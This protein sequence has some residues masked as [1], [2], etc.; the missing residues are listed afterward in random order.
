MVPNVLIDV[1]ESYVSKKHM[2]ADVMSTEDSASGPAG[3][4]AEA[5]RRPTGVADG[6]VCE[7]DIAVPI[8]NCW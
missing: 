3:D 8:L 4:R 6:A 7:V 1:T 5:G 2:S